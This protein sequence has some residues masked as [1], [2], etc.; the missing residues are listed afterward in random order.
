M[1]IR[2]TDISDNWEVFDTERGIVAGNDP[3]LLLEDTAAEYTAKDF[4]DPYSSGFAVTTE[5]SKSG[6]SYIFY[7]IA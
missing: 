5:L 6:G 1:L 2:R 7:A 4:V 3:R